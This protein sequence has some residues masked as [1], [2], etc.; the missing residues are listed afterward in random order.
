MLKALP[1]LPILFTLTLSSINAEA[2]KK[3]KPQVQKLIGTVQKC[4]DGD[5][6]RVIVDN[7]NLKI[8]F[9]GI[10]TPELSQK[11]G[12]EA[13]DFTESKLK[14]KVVRLECEGT[15]FDRLTCTIFME[16]RNINREI[17]LNGWA[18]DSTKYSK[19]IY[20]QDVEGAKAKQLGIWKDP[21]LVSPYCYRHKTNKKCRVSQ[22][23]MP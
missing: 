7:K 9:A 17:V 23:Y 8:R 3:K 16:G 1:L 2:R 18:F 15:S 14:N 12:K 11:Y 5:T 6:C 22:L 21:K 20:A 4:H 19:G 13:R 10:D